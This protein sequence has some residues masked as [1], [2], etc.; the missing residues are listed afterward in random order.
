MKKTLIISML[1]L[2]SACMM[3]GCK[4]KN[5]VDLTSAHT[6]AADETM[7]AAETLPTTE[8]AAEVTTA[9]DETASAQS[10]TGASISTYKSGKVSIEYPAVSESTSSNAAAVNELLKKNAVSAVKAYG[11]NES[12]DTMTIKCNV[13]SVNNKR[14]TAVYTGEVTAAGAAH[15]TAVYF[16]NTV[17]L[18]KASDV[19]L[20]TYADPYTMAGYVMSDDCKFYNLTAEQEKAV[21][22]YK[23]SQSID[24]YNKLF[25]QADFPLRGDTFP[26][27]FSY[28][29]QG[30]IRI[31]IPVPHALGDY[32]IVVFTPETK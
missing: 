14:L 12:S 6:T 4:S 1:V 30:E 11:V 16:T 2:T 10:G 24:T 23:N 32:A 25:K 21:K 18:N 5:K 31:S 20:S 26:E 28:E 17:D 19:G 8:E 15:P 7:S 27:C 3:W 29:K 9:A 13:V 22:E